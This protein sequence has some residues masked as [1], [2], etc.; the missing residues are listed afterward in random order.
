[1]LISFGN[2]FA[3]SII[4]NLESFWRIGYALSFSADISS[5]IKLFILS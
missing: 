2:V 5:I 3:E 1:M 4:P